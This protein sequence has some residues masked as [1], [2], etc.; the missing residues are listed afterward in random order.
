MSLLSFDV[1]AVIQCHLVSLVL[2]VMRIFLI[3]SI[4][5][6]LKSLEYSILIYLYF[7]EQ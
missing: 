1:I 5:F 4:Y 3:L 7:L 2:G 6:G